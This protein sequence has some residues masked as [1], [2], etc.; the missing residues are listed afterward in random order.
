MNPLDPTLVGN[1]SKR[2]LIESPTRTV[3]A[4]GEKTLTWSPVA[5]V[6]G[7]WEDLGGTET[8]AERQ[9]QAEIVS[10]VT[11]RYRSGVTAMCRV[12]LGSRVAEVESALNLDGIKR[13]LT[14]TCRRKEG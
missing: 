5:T 6:W 8:V 12:T 7:C 4:N 11:V 13:F 10:R 2:I 3:A 1:M 14:L 9:T